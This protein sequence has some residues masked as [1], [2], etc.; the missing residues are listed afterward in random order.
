MLG[1][2]GA[3]NNTSV[4]ILSTTGV[5]SLST[6]YTADAT[7]LADRTITAGNND[8]TFNMGAGIFLVNGPLNNSGV[9]STSGATFTQRTTN[10]GSTNTI[11]VSGS[12]LYRGSNNLERPVSVD[13]S[14]IL[15]SGTDG[16]V[17]LTSGIICSTLGN[18]VLD[19]I[20][21]VNLTSPA[22]GYLLSFN[23]VNWVDVDPFMIGLLSGV[24]RNNCLTGDGTVGSPLSIQLDPTGLIT[25]GS[26]GLKITGTLGLISVSVS[27]CVGGSGTSSSPVYVRLDPTGYITCGASGLK[28]STVPSDNLGNHIATATLNMSG[29]G[30][31]NVHSLN[32][33][34]G[35]SF[36]Y[37]G[38]IDRLDVTFNFANRFAF[39]DSGVFSIFTQPLTNNSLSGVLVWNPDGSI[40]LR[41]DSSIAGLSS[42]TTA[43]CFTGNGTA[44]TPLGLKLDPSGGI[45][46][47]ANGLYLFPL[48]GGGCSTAFSYENLGYSGV[49]TQ[50]VTPAVSSNIQVEVLNNAINFFAKPSGSWI[51]DKTFFSTSGLASVSVTGCIIGSGTLGSPIS[52]QLDP[53]G[54][55][56]CGAA[57]LRYTGPTG[58]GGGGLGS[59]ITSGCIIGDGTAGNAVRLNLDPTGYINCGPS[60]LKINDSFTTLYVNSGCFQGAGT[61]GDALAL[62]LHP[63]GLLECSAS[64]LRFTGT[65]TPDSYFTGETD[66]GNSGAAATISFVSKANQKLTLTA[67][68]TLTFTAPADARSVLI[69]FVQDSTGGRTVTPPGSV[70][71][72]MPTLASGVSEQTV[73]NFY[74]DGV[75]YHV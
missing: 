53:T 41:T 44:S 51:F 31:T 26:S 9:I 20:G 60:G 47:G 30:I 57:G 21:D 33:V 71:G 13:T 24:A 25:C 74:Y 65:L 72:T 14:N 34:S 5:F 15:V 45:I 42:V 37:D 28:L 7:I 16:K 38:D 63:T 32:Y 36:T 62:R 3:G 68:C 58:T 23:G 40:N 54:L 70:L 46:C 69:R 12:N 64:G 66:N 59:V 8:L 22:N 4:V 50:P 56:V 49:P 73:V 17:L 48:S 2:F 11:W 55:L 61:S 35:W 52:V 1:D 39:G 43:G 19:N 75:N 27:G 29:Y 10:P 18:C 67:N 6:I